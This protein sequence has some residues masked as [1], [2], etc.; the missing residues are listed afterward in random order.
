MSKTRSKL[1]HDFEAFVQYLP[2]FEKLDEL[3]S[4]VPK[5]RRADYAISNRRVIIEQ[6][7][8]KQKMA[9]YKR[10]GLEA[11]F[12]EITGK[13]G[14]DVGKIL[15]EMADLDA[16]SHLNLLRIASRHTNFVQGAFSEANLQIGGT[17]AL[18]QLSWAHGLLVILNDHVNGEVHPKEIEWRVSREFHRLNDAGQRRYPN[19]WSVLVII[20][21]KSQGVLTNALDIGIQHA[22]GDVWEPP[23][24]ASMISD[25]YNSANP[26]RTGATVG[27]ISPN[28][29]WPLINYGR[30]NKS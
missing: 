29:F 23:A 13:I 6:K 25:F 15:E 14:Y 12:A 20:H 4:N 27:R 19:V 17:I 28:L 22:S 24:I 26:Y 3:L 11:K 30:Q 10:E 8:T 2:T 16:A 1:L 9:A 5:G 18:L 7:Y 21:H